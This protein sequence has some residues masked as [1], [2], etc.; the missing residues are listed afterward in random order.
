MT[1]QEAFDILVKATGELSANRAT[2]FM[3][4]Q[5][6]DVIGEIIKKKEGE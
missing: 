3:I 2:H 5:A 4:Q 6:L 1:P